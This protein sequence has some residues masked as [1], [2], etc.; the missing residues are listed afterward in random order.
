[1]SREGYWI[2][3]FSIALALMLTLLPLP[4]WARYFR[5]E[6]VALICIYWA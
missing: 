1:M 4:D 6:W 3:P 2:V 5:P